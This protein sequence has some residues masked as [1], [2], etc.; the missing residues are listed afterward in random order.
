[1]GLLLAPLAPAVRAARGEGDARLTSAVQANVRLGVDRLRRDPL[2][3]ERIG[4]G[5]LRVEGAYY[6]LESGRVRFL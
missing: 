1:V 6:S 5:V 2:L 3:R 4:R